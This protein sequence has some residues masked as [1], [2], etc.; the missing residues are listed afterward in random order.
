MKGVG[1]MS[2]FHRS[3]PKMAWLRLGRMTNESTE[4]ENYY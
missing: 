1:L 3:S 4:T 2:D